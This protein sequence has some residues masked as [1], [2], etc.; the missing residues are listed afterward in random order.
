MSDARFYADKCLRQLFSPVCKEYGMN[1]MALGKKPEEVGIINQK[2]LN[3]K[4][5]MFII[6]ATE[7]STERR[8][9]FY[10]AYLRLCSGQSQTLA[11]RLHRPTAM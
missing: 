6:F 3:R 8:L 7:R 10:A 5:A 11:S 2:G 9:L 4:V 1:L